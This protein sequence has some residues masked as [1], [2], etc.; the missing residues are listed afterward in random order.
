MTTAIVGGPVTWEGEIGSDGYR[1]YTVVHRVVGDDTPGFADGPANVLQTPGLPTPGSDWF[2]DG[3]LD[4]WAWHTGEKRAIPELDDGDRNRFWRVESK[5]SNKP[6]DRQRCMDTQIEDPLLEPPRVSGSFTKYVEEATYDR[7][8]DPILN[9]AHEVIRGPAVEFDA[10]RPQIRIEMN[11]PTF[12]TVQLAYSMIDTVNITGLWGF[13]PR[14][15]KLSNA[16][17]EKKYYGTCNVY[18]TITLEF[19]VRAIETFDKDVLDEGT[20]VLNG[21]WDESS[22]AW[23][24]VNIGGAAPDPENPQHFCRFQD[25]NGN[26]S[27]VILDGAGLPAEVDIG[28]GSGTF[29]SDAGSLHIEKY[30][31]SDFLLLGVPLTF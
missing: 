24:L 14:C 29:A 8:G 22:G 9:S 21:R 3:D 5:F 27:R 4:I 12:T 16:P 11:V 17:W 31:Q 2:F 25:R 26:M 30:G 7:N 23:V 13:N 1:N 28:T 18:Y 19:D 10:N 20:K 15:I 6:P